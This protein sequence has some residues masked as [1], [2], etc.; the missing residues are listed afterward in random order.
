[1]GMTRAVGALLML[2]ALSGCSD[3]TAG[4]PSAEEGSIAEC[5]DG[6]LGCPC[7]NNGTCNT[8]LECDAGVCDEVSAEE[9]GGGESVQPG[10]LGAPCEGNMD[11]DS[12]FCVAGPDGFYCTIPCLSECPD[13][14]LCKQVTN[15][16]SDLIF[17]CVPD[18][19]FDECHTSPDD[20][21][22]D[23]GNAC[24]V[25]DKCKDGWCMGGTP[26]DCDDGNP[27]TTP[28]CNFKSGC[29]YTPQD[30][31]CDDGDLCTS[32]DF[33]QD[34]ECVGSGSIDCSSD[35]PCLVGVCAA[36]EGCVYEEVV[37]DDGDPSTI[38]FCSL[39]G[40]KHIETCDKLVNDQALCTLSGSA[41]EA[42]ECELKL[43]S[44]S[45]AAT[46][47]YGLQIKLTYP[48]SLLTL[49]QFTA[50]SSCQDSVPP[51]S[52]S[53]GH[54]VA[55]AP[56]D[57][58]EWNGAGEILIVNLGLPSPITTAIY[59]GGSIQ[60]S[61]EF[62]T[63]RFVLD[64]DIPEWAPIPVLLTEAEASDGNAA[65]LSKTLKDRTILTEKILIPCESNGQPCDDFNA[66]TTGDICIAKVC[67]GEEKPCDDGDPC[68]YD[69][70]DV[71]A[72]CF[73]GLAGDGCAC[74]DGD[75]CTLETSCQTGLCLGSP[76]PSCQ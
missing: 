13:G 55:L 6:T 57:T 15:A 50:C 17:L 48:E 30:G 38:D 75:P 71:N 70:C 67:M 19:N 27:C 41:G 40:C 46:H 76:H 4:S 24:T 32:G 20:A 64:V 34:G 36:F 62:M 14:Y 69:H 11:C 52:L 9:T 18:Q 37:C 31:V 22:C 25:D 12:Q 29:E 16:G 5:E 23:D 7:Y 61:S 49:T 43:A 8:G 2:L 21:A 39:D 33:C 53:T 59:D 44:A 28:G 60:G 26:L 72:G 56:E 45:L 10:G 63:A 73:S 3:E 1:M 74:D 68:T 65:P 42:V 35:D 51:M 58:D 47:A 54:F 66:C